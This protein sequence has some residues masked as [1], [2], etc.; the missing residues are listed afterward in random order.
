MA[1]VV[2]T[3]LDRIPFWGIGEFTA[4]FRLP[5]FVVEPEVP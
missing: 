5:I 3:V 1:V 4:H 2:K